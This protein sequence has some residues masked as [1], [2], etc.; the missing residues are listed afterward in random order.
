MNDRELEQALSRFYAQSIPSSDETEFL[1]KLERRWVIRRLYRNLLL[2]GLGSIGALATGW[3][4]IEVGAFSFL[5]NI[6]SALATI[7]SR[8]W[9]WSALAVSILLLPIVIRRIATIGPYNGA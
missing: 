8:S 4:M 7:E 1:R 9:S 3:W 2:G 5:A 6:H